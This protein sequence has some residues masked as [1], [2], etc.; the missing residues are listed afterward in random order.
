MAKKA[1]LLEQLGKNIRN[2]QINNDNFNVEEIDVE[3]LK[4]LKEKLR[5]NITDYRE[6]ISYNP[7]ENSIMITFLGLMA[8]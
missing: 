6:D 3:V 4:D 1:K 8:N 2:I 7:L 5:E